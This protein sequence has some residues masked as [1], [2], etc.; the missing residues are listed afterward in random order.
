MGLSIYRLVVECR[1]VSQIERLDDERDVPRE[2]RGTC[3]VWFR[4]T[5]L[6]VD[7]STN[8]INIYG[9]LKSLVL[10]SSSY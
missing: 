6:G 3:Y 9:V 5:F 7:A 8:P 4:I 10:S 2:S 1:F